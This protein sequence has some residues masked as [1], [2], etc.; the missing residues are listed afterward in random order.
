VYTDY[1]KRAP[2][3]LATMLKVGRLYQSIGAHEAAMTAF[4]YVAERDPHNQALQTMLA[5][6]GDE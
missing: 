2:D 1:L 3:D 4:R 5:A 6:A